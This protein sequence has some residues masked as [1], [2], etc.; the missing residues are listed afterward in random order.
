M[1]SANR[2]L[3]SWENFWS[4]STG[5]PEEIFWDADPVHAAQQ[6]LALFQD[7]ADPQLPLVGGC[8]VQKKFCI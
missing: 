7:Y 8:L 3:T 1:T 4:T 5:A 2:Y 6:D